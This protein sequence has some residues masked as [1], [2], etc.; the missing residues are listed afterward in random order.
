MEFTSSSKLISLLIL[1]MVNLISKKIFHDY[2][3][4]QIGVLGLYVLGLY[5]PACQLLSPYK[6]H[7][8]NNPGLLRYIYELSR[9]IE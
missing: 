4:V 7:I 2:I 8:N 5:L 6:N 1:S 3:H 9:S